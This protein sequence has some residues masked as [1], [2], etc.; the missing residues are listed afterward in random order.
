MTALAELLEQIGSGLPLPATGGVRLLP[1]PTGFAVGAVLGFTG[2]HVIAADA[3][4]GWLMSQLADSEIGR[5]LNPEFLAAL[6]G[7]LDARPGGQDVLLVAGPGTQT[8]PVGEAVAENPTTLD[9]LRVERAL[10][11]RD[12]VRVATLSGGLVTVG[13]GLARRWEISIEVAESGRNAGLG[14]ALA[15]YGRTLVPAG[16][17][18]W[19]Q[20]HPANVASLRAFLAAGY[21]PVGAEVL[22]ARGLA[23]R[24]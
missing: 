21:R 23:A 10:R 16:A 22:F 18:L 12:D 14:R 1:G 19:A 6:G 8:G 2:H 11:Y 9:H 20:V 3:D 5:P 24:R 13:R 4:P 15:A 7:H 17:A